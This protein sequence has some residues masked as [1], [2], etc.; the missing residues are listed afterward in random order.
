MGKIRKT[1]I[2]GTDILYFCTCCKEYYKLENFEIRKD[3]QKPRSSC[4]KCRK[5]ESRLYHFMRRQKFSEEMMNEKV[6]QLDKRKQDLEYHNKRYLLQRAKCHAK[7]K[8]IEISITWED[9]KIPKECPILKHPF[10]LLDPKYT[11]SIDR[12]DNTKGYVPG[13]IAIISRLANTMKNCASK[14]ELQLF[15]KNI[16]KYIE[17]IV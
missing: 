15:S 11:Y 12:I 13:N 7:A 2:E 14:K 6:I 17:E 9:I 4:K 10:V 1:K 8:N 5:E 3:T 16:L